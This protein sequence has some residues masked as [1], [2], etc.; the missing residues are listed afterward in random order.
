MSALRNNSALVGSLIPFTRS[1]ISPKS[2][3]SKSSC[4]RN[5]LGADTTASFPGPSKTP[6]SAIANSPDGYTTPPKPAPLVTGYRSPIQFACT[7]SWDSRSLAVLTRQYFRHGRSARLRGTHMMNDT[8]IRRT[9]SR[10]SPNGQREVARRG[11]L[12]DCHRCCEFMVAFQ[13]LHQ[14]GRH[15]LRWKNYGPRNY[16]GCRLEGILPMLPIV[17]RCHKGVLL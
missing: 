15:I 3:T 5:F 1:L 16:R 17:C 7:K 6:V 4:T 11:R 14:D 2:S 13:N 10:H 8:G 9:A 12:I